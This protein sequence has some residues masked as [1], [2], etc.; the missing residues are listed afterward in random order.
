M[1]LSAVGS[2]FVSHVMI[3]DFLLEFLSLD[4]SHL[5]LT[6]D[7]VQF[8]STMWKF[9][10]FV[11]Y[12]FFSSSV[13]SCS[14]W[15]FFSIT[16]IFNISYIVSFMLFFLVLAWRFTICF[17][18]CITVYYQTILYQFRVSISLCLLAQF[19]VFFENSAQG[20]LVSPRII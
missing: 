4:H 16:F 13:L 8:K 14:K 19:L 9:V 3:S 17:F 15:V 18:Y 1:L 20:L 7:T 10:K 11:P 12:C 5:M 2:Y 6:I